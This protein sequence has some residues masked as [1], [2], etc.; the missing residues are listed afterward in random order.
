MGLPPEPIVPRDGRL[1]VHWNDGRENEQEPIWFVLGVR[2]VSH[3][4][5]ESERAGGGQ[6]S[7]FPPAGAG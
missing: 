2:R 5:A 7:G 6:R 3:T 4:G 1:V